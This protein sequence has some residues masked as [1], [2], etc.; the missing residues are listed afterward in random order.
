MSIKVL[1]ISI[2]VTVLGSNHHSTI[3][4]A[5]SSGAPVCIV[6]GSGV[7]ASHLSRPSNITGSI[8]FGSF[9]VKIGSKTLNSSIVNN[10]AAE[11]NLPVV[12]SS[13]NGTQFLGVL[14]VLNQPNVS[15]VT[16]LFLAPNS[17][18]FQNQAGC[19]PLNYSGFTHTN[20]TAKTNATATIYLPF[21]QAAFLDVNV[22]VANNA[23]ISIFFYTRYQLLTDPA[24]TKS[25]TKKPTKAP[26]KAPAKNAT[27]V[28]TKAPTKA[29]TRKKC[30]LFKLSI[31]C[32][33]GCGF[34]G[35]LFGWCD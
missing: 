21:G 20:N 14:I 15:L 6:G 7:R 13:T 25:P 32:F 31:L 11:T 34:A 24:P 1:I 19:A 33:N 28:P 30:G 5:L 12:L 10:V 23:N 4:Y 22:V 35:R 16:N 18:D 26:T 29:P 2:L 17:S 3:V 27:K 9:T 8:E